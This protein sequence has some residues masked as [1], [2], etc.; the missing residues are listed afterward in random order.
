MGMP[1]KAFNILEL[2]LSKVKVGV[3]VDRKVFSHGSAYCMLA[4]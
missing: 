3:D 2:G 4:C 1:D